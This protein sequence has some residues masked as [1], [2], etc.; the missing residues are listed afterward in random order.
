MYPF[1]I[2]LL[3]PLFRIIFIPF[4]SLLCS[5]SGAQSLPSSQTLQNLQNV[6]GSG[7]SLS[8]LGG[9]IASGAGGMN[10]GV[11]ALG[12]NVIQGQD[13]VVPANTKV[14][15]PVFRPL[16]PNPFQQFVL[17]VTGQSYPL[18]G[19][20]FFE[21]IHLLEPSNLE[22]NSSPALSGLTNLSNPFAPDINAPVS[23]DYVLGPGDQL[24]IR[25]WGSIDLN[26]K[27]VIDRNGLISLPKVGTITLSGVNFSA[28]HGVINQSLSN[29]YKNFELSVSIGQ[30]RSITVYVVGQARRPGS[31][32]LSSLS[33]IST[34]LFASGGPN[35]TGSMRHV[36][37]K[38]SGSVVSEFD[39]YQFLSQGESAGDARLIDG[40]VIVMPAA[41]GYVA[42]V[43]KLS[44]PAIYELKS[45]D[46]TLE[47]LLSVAG[48]LSVT[49]DPRSA[50]LERL[51]ANQDQP[52]TVKN[53]DLAQGGLKTTLKSGDLVNFYSITPELKNSVTLRGNVTVP[54]R[55]A[56]H[57]GLRI[58]DLI[59]NRQVLMSPDSVRRQNEVLF[60]ANE[61]ERTQRSRENIPSDLLTPNDYSKSMI[62][63]TNGAF[64][65]STSDISKINQTATEQITNPNTSEWE[66]LRQDRL[67][68]EQPKIDDIKAHT[69][70]DRVGQILDQVN[71]EYAVV[72]RVNRQ[73]LTLSLIP[74][75]LGMAIDHE[76]SIDNISLEPGDIVTVFSI[77]DIRVPVSK[78]R[79]L[80]KLEGEVARPGIYQATPGDTLISILKRAGGVTSDAYLFGAGFY[81]EDVRQ[82]QA[83]NLEKLLRRLESESN[84]SI[85]QLSQSSG[86]STNAS[87]IQAKILA[88]QQ[89]QREAIVRLKS[90]KPEGRISLGL[91]ANLKNSVDELPSLHLQNNDHFVI[92]PRPDFVYVFGSV[93]TESALIFKEGWSVQDYLAF[94]GLGS[95]ADRDAVILIRADG[96]ALTSSSSWRNQVLGANVLPGDTI[97]VPDELDRESLWSKIFRNTL[98]GTQI[99]Y[100]LGL[101]AAA[102]KTLKN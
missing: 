4:L 25:A 94:S 98:D 81:R 32:T 16:P 40:D 63:D 56:W 100:Q 88:A 45:N 62:K 38:R 97:V 33:T 73:D 75:N 77:D 58:H 54:K 84:A 49:T 26:Y 57:E 24:L 72:E 86:A 23:K 59:P 93:N 18:F 29:I 7:G 89:T 14:P 79:I 90:L 44:T 83:Q 96:S 30:T 8:G 52:R 95:G 13:P 80:V 85:A 12:S 35:S 70:S 47:Q 76:N 53:I 50:R 82:S 64:R 17:Q 69:L 10:G 41:M 48:G 92:P 5:L 55:L 31:Y 78:R 19:A 51:D 39:L 20:N 2:R 74:F 1:N 15:V 66:K 65:G 9:S 71:F 68:A 87:L 3:L 46:E 28:A 27:A 43:G 21:N 91:Q 42:L 102:I 11:N 22:T 101:G 60:D 36:Q 61:R 99:F 67:F 34:A 37:L 6:I